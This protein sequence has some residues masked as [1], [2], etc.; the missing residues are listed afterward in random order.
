MSMTFNTREDVFHS[1]TFDNQD[2][3]L[4]YVKER[5]EQFKKD[6]YT[7]AEMSVR[8]YYDYEGTPANIAVGDA[9][10]GYQAQVAAQ[11]KAAPSEKPDAA[12]KIN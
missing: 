2:E 10:V 8:E 9:I 12:P 3:A 11:K 1:K 7:V 5:G 4:K 6:G